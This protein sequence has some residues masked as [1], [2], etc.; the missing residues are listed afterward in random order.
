MKNWG[1]RCFHCQMPLTVSS[2]GFCCRCYRLLDKT[3]YC[4]H[5][6]SSLLSYH[7]SCGNC[8]RNEPKWHRI[9]QIS[10]YNSP[11]ADWIH[12]FKFQ[13]QYWLDKPLARLLLLAVRNARR[14]HFL[15]LP[16]VI[17]PVPLFWQRYW[18]RGY[19]QAELIARHLSRWL[20]IPLDCRSLQRK[21]ATTPQREL[22]AKERK[23]NLKGA[24]TYCPAQTYQRIA[25]VDDVVTTG[26]TL[27]AICA[28]LLKQ[29]VK[30]IQVWTLARA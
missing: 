22:T 17:M 4:G 23:R 28:E 19:N 14:E 18:H 26:S 6:G 10:A 9:V 11:L 30:E 3:P 29:D 2:H 27:N 5:C 7:N 25:I 1:F 16:E 20:A 8:L 13:R 21:K 24:F 12:Q 15:T